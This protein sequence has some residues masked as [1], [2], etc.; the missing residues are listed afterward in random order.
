MY[1]G[2]CCGN[3]GACMTYLLSM[4][5]IAR[6]ASLTSAYVTNPEP[7]CDPSARRRIFTSRTVP[8]VAK[9]IRTSASPY[10]AGMLPTYSFGEG[11]PYCGPGAGTGGHTPGGGPDATDA[12]FGRDARS[13]QTRRSVTGT[14]EPA[15]RS[16]PAAPCVASADAARAASAKA[17]NAARVSGNVVT[18]HAA[19]ASTPNKR[20]M[21]CSEAPWGSPT[22]AICRD[23]SVGPEPFVSVVSVASFGMS[24]VTSSAAS[25]SAYAAAS[26]SRLR[27]SPAAGAFT[28]A[29]GSRRFV[30][31][32]GVGPHQVTATGL[33]CVSSKR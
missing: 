5:W 14:G 16:V 33:S 11:S 26:S 17:T 7:L 8:T 32:S 21:S 28:L 9:I 23:E 22:T 15:G 25:A 13:T 3:P 20:A 29:A 24:S 19:F 18:K 27:F 4:K 30:A 12:A 31:T 6:S 2:F 10:C 1:T